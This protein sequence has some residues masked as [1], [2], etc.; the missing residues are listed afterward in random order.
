MCIHKHI[1]VCCNNYCCIFDCVNI[2]EDDDCLKMNTILS[3]LSGVLLLS[4]NYH[5]SDVRG[6]YYVYCS[7]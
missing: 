4:L 3:I 1:Y 2:M 5:I 6:L 7:V